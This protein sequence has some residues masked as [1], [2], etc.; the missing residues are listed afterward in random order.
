MIAQDSLEGRMLPRKRKKGFR[1]GQDIR[2][3]LAPVF[4]PH[5]PFCYTIRLV[6]GTAQGHEK[7]VILLPADLRGFPAVLPLN[8][9]IHAGEHAVG[10]TLDKIASIGKP[11]RECGGILQDHFMPG[12]CPGIP[13]G[14]THS[15]VIS[16]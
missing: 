16:L 13:I 15:L 5:S 10:K 7:S 12:V 11:E 14:N 2:I 9:L 1:V 3:P 4:K 8:A 6:M